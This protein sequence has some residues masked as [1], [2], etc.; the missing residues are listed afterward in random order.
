M[1]TTLPT[2]MRRKW[3][4]ILQH[5]RSSF[6]QSHCWLSWEVQSCWKRRWWVTAVVQ[7]FLRYINSKGSQF[8]TEPSIIK[9]DANKDLISP[10]CAHTFSIDQVWKIDNNLQGK[11]QYYT[12]KIACEQAHIWEHTRERQRANSKARRSGG[13]ESGFAARVTI[14]ASPLMCAPASLALNIRSLP[15]ARVLPNV[16]LHAGFF[17]NWR[18]TVNQ[19]DNLKI[20]SDN[21]RLL[22]PALWQKEN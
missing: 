17:Q 1:Q 19:S 14:A 2:R 16:S 6:S 11:L 22:F 4:D 10:L 7:P 9:N 15:L 13:E 21:D 18:R 12:S 20:C 8:L 5:M 3:R